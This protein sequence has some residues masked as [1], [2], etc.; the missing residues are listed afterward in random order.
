MLWLKEN[1]NIYG[2]KRIAKLVLLFFKSG[3]LKLKCRQQTRQM[4]KISSA[5]NSASKGGRI[6]VTWT[7]QARCNQKKSGLQL[8]DGFLLHLLAFFCLLRCLNLSLTN[9]KMLTVINNS[10]MFIRRVLIKLQWTCK[11]PKNFVKMCRPWFSGSSVVLKNF[12]FLA[13]SNMILV[14]YAL[15]SKVLV[16]LELTKLYN[17]LSVL[18]M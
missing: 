3:T 4:A 7:V 14:D 12:L 8:Q 10:L 18:K 13:S 6:L 17:K 11:L 16:H 2:W 9:Q 5:G 1:V 15:S